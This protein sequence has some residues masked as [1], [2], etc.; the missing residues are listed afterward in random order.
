[1]LVIAHRGAR[2]EEP[3]NTLRALR[4]AAECKADAVEVDARRCKSGEIV[5]IHDETLERTTNGRGRVREHTLAA[6]KSLNA[7]KGERIP[8]LSE[9]LQLAKS[10][11]MKIVVEM[12][13]EGIE[14]DVLSE[15]QRAG[16]ANSTIIS[17][18]Y[19]R[20]LLRLKE[21]S[22]AEEI[23]TGIIIASLPVNPLNLAFEAKADAIFARYPRLDERMVKEAHEHRIEVFPW[24]VNDERALRDVLRMGVDG[25]VTDDPCEM[26]R[27]LSEIEENGGNRGKRGRNEQNFSA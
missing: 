22:G 12:K 27:I 20:S 8:T 11:R 15:I 9:V 23:K 24:T 6:L 13:E 21:L 25:F 7:G 4:R 3:E 2:T 19:H 17:S 14:K 1:M 10:L 16:M 5:V 26:R 18:F